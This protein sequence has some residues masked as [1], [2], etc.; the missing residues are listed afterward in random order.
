M[1]TGIKQGSRVLNNQHAT[2]IQTHNILPMTQNAPNPI[3]SAKLRNGESSLIISLRVRKSH[4]KKVAPQV[5]RQSQIYSYSN[6]QNTGAF[7]INRSRI[8]PPPIA[9]IV[10]TIVQPSMSMPIHQFMHTNQQQKEIK[11]LFIA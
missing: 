7:P 6:A 8:V 4:D 10:P 9:V 11:K 2:I 1:P 3:E 5:A